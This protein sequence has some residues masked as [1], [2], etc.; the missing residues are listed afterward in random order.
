[1]AVDEGTDT[2]EELVFVV[3]MVLVVEVVFVVEV[4]DVVAA[5]P[6]MHWL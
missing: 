1:V 6:G 3:E 5:E 2:V 4:L